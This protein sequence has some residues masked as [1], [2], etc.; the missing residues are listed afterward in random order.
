MDKPKKLWEK[1]K[2]EQGRDEFCFNLQSNIACNT[3]ECYFEFRG[4]CLALKLL[5]HKGECFT[6]RNLVE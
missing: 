4:G 3:E 5:I 2:E 1:L 6:D